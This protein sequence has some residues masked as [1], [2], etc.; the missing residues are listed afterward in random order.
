MTDAPPNW[1]P[2]PSGQA[3]LRYWDGR[4][5]TDYTQGDRT[6]AAGQQPAAAPPPAAPTA[7]GAVPGAGPAP[8]PAG[9]P[10]SGSKGAGK[11]PLIVGGALVAVALVVVLVLA[12][13]GGE[14]GGGEEAKVEEAI[15][16]VATSKDP[17]VC[18]ERHT[19]S[20]LQKATGLAGGAA[21]QL[22]EETTPENDVTGVETSDVKVNGTSADAKAKIEG[23]DYDGETLTIDLQKQDGEW[24]VNDL[25]RPEVASGPAAEQAIQTAVLNFGTA[26]GIAACDYL[27][28]AGLER[29][30]GRSG[31]ETQFKE[32]QPANYSIQDVTVS[33]T[34]AT[35][36]VEETRQSKTIEFKLTRELGEWEIDSF[37]QR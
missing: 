22:C 27:S 10:G 6:V 34:S 14:E 24:K 2:D 29:L 7:A 26:E 15:E 20:Y 11:L 1:Y 16:E 35:A 17:A 31:C 12:G 37:A 25:D 19:T 18:E 23:G 13:G 36:V 5:W 9:S 21:V 4:Q 8:G 3:E 28:Y 33:G 30:G 32:G